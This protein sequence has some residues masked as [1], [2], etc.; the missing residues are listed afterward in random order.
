MTHQIDDTRQAGPA[1][2]QPASPWRPLF[3]RGWLGRIASELVPHSCS[4]PDQADLIGFF[5]GL[6]EGRKRRGIRYPQWFLLLLAI[7]GVYCFAEG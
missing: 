3:F 1:A 4:T 5:Q 7:L 6:P 2:S